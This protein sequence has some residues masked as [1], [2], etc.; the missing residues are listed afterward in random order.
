MTMGERKKEGS[1]NIERPHYEKGN[2]T[3]IIMLDRKR[4]LEDLIK[5][6][7]KALSRAPEGYLRVLDRKTYAEYYWRRTPDDMNGAFIPKR[8]WETAHDL[9]QKD[10]DI[11]ILKRAERELKLVDK[12]L[13][14]VSDNSI[15]DVYEHLSQKRKVLVVPYR[16][17]DKGFVQKWMEQTYEPMG[18]EKDAPEY[19]SDNGLRVRSKSEIIIANLLEKYGVPFKYEFPLQLGKRGTVRPDFFCLNVRTRK[20]YIWEH[21]G[22]MDDENYAQKN[23]QKINTY[24]ENGFHAGINMIMT[25]ETSLIPVN[26]IIIKK[27]IENCLT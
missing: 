7:K 27:M 12:Y 23:V 2:E 26:S 4:E 25:F 18:F 21:F 19:Y 3:R 14:F 6:K 13:A 8:E 24:A 1:Q 5:E 10:Y 17:P 16:I 20:E 22:M 15:S 9:A 11:R